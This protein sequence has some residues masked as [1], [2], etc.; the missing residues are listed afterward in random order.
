MKR[1]GADMRLIRTKNKVRLPIKINKKNVEI[2][3]EGI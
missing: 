1:E 2:L 3:K